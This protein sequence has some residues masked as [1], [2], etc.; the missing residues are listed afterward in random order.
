MKGYRALGGRLPAVDVFAGAGGLSQGLGRAGF[1]VVVASEWDDDA[2][3]TFEAGHPRAEVIRGD[4]RDALRSF[5]RLR[6][7][8]ALVAGGPPCQPWSSGGK[9]LG[10]ADPRDGLP[11]FIEVV[12]RVRP[13]AFILENV[14]GLASSHRV[15]ELRRHVQ[16]LEEMGFTVSWRVLNAASY[17]VPQKRSRLFVVGTRDVA[18]VFPK[19]TH[20]EGRRV[21]AGTVVDPVA[22]K[23]DP[24]PSIVTYAKKPDLRPSPYHGHLWNGGGRPI[25]LAEP[26]PTLLASMGGNKTP[27]LD[28]D[29]VVPGY[30]RYLAQGGRPHRG[31]V[32]GARRITV[33]EAAAL[34]TFGRSTK[35]MGKRSS[36][37]RQVGNAVPPKLAHA[38]A[39]PLYELIAKS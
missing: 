38:V 10:S 39:K 29:N 27:W 37:Y 23:G 35:F 30:H 2:A 7:E 32:P 20:P 19:E 24:N 13:T 22:V 3:D 9:R 34:Q 26:A 16:A 36:Q 21:A 14:A 25:N 8:V 18:Y 6:G 28:A 4:L 17:G 5:R 15:V 31:R 12:E 11:L 1:E 33:S